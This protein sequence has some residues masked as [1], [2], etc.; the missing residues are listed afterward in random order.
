MKIR[1]AEP[2]DADA[3]IA[4]DEIAQRKP[5][6]VAFIRR[7]TSSNDCFVAVTDGRVVGYAVLNYRFYDNGFIDMLYVDRR[8]RR[9]G[10]GSA[11]LSHVEQR[12]TTAKLFTSTNQ[13]NTP[14]Q[15]LLRKSGYLPSGM[16]ENLDEGDSELVYMKSL[17]SDVQDAPSGSDAEEASGG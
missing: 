5:P 4:F 6:R 14:M 2:S 16:I 17:R 9:G 7:S 1:A 10:I 12:C 11:L 8:F 3:I 15:L 13:S